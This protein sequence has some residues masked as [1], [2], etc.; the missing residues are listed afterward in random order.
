MPNTLRLNPAWFNRKRMLLYALFVSL[1]ILFTALYWF[2]MQNKWLIADYQKQNIMSAEQDKLQD[3]V[4][5]IQTAETILNRFADSGDAKLAMAF[6]ALVDSI[7]AHSRKLTVYQDLANSSINTTP[8]RDLSRLVKDKID[9]MIQAKKLCEKQNCDS[10]RKMIGSGRAIM[11]T[12]SILAIHHA[13]NNA[14]VVSLGSSKKA[15]YAENNKYYK[16]VFW[17]IL[18]SLL[19]TIGSLYYLLKGLQK[20]ES[21]TGALMLERGHLG[22]TLSSIGEGLIT[23]DKDGNIIYMNPAAEKLTGWS[24]R[25]I[26]NKPLQ[27]VYNVFD[28]ETGLPAADMVNIAI[29]DNKPVD[30]GRNILLHTKKGGVLA[31]SN[32]CSPLNDLEGNVLGAVLLFQDITDRKRNEEKVR[33][34]IERYEILSKA[35][36]DT[37]WD[38][39]IMND[40]ILYNHSMTKMFGYTKAEINKAAGW[41]RSNLHPDDYER[42]HVTLDQEFKVRS[43]TIQ[44][45]YRYRCADKTFKH[46]LDRAYVIYDA[47]GNPVRMI[48][49]MQDITHEKEHERQIAIAITDAQEKERRELG[50]EL[51]DNVNQLLGATL[52]YLGMITKSGTV[53]DEAL[54]ILKDCTQYINDAISTLRNLS[55]RL[56]PHAKKQVSL[57]QLIELLIQPIKATEQYDIH[58]HVESIENGI[59]EPEIQTNLYRIVQEQLTNI[60]K[61]ADA[62]QIKISIWLTKKLIKLNI[63]DNG[64]GFDTSSLKDG[65]G[66]ENMK[67]RAEMFSG[68]I[69]FIS[70]PGKGCELLVEMP[71]KTSTVKAPA[72]KKPSTVLAAS[73]TII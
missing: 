64:K 5:D 9:L 52:L 32:N 2:A 17:V 47:E 40:N 36:S 56:T 24:I 49:A 1:M 12:D 20:V 29:R 58:L 46:I 4:R 55:H 42:V 39:D 3:L 65:I 60:L 33:K 72:R 6:P 25:E 23:T 63:S 69:K 57:K 51:H 50:M 30:P 53:K 27:T 22:I 28:Q 59:I 54:R 71:L 31:I 61:H 21:V 13:A 68:K 8:F 41:W 73:T 18:I 66:L 67:R 7:R 62:S 19:S 48:G 11:I 45:E 15:F 26:R 14:M 70:A 44:I 43:E 10:A 38:W 16:I 34:A 35:T 37:I